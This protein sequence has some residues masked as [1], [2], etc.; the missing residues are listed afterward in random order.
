ME[1]GAFAPF[2]QML[3]FPY[4]FKY[5]VFQR[6]QKAVFNPLY[7]N[8]LSPYILIQYVQHGTAQCML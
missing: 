5:L 8:G 6:P 3:H 4:F 7:S 1:N 2:E